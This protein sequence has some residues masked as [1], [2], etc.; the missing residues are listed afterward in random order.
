MT[1]T[2]PD[3]QLDQ[4]AQ[5]GQPG[6]ETSLLGR[7]VALLTPIFAVAAAWVAG[8]VARAVP[9]AHLDQN[10]LVAFMATAAAAALAAALKWL[11][12]WQQHERLVAEGMEQPRGKPRTKQPST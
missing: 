2:Q 12:G 6:G 10:Q 11:H 9:G 5:A 1:I 8:A 4:G 7:F 3:Q